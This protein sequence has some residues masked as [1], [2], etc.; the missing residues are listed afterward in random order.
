MLNKLASFG[1]LLLVMLLLAASLLPVNAAV[2]TGCV[3]TPQTTMLQLTA[4]QLPL[5]SVAAKGDVASALLQQ[6]TDGRQELYQL[7]SDQ[8]IAAVLWL[9]VPD[10]FRLEVYQLFQGQPQLL[11][12][13]H[14]DSPFSARATGTA[15]LQVPLQ[16][17]A[18]EHQI[19]LKYYIHANGRL[20]PHLYSPQALQSAQSR[21][22][23]LNGLL[24]GGMLTMLLVI[25]LYGSVAESSSYLAY[26][27]LVLAQVLM[28][29]QFEGYYFQWLWPDAPWWNVQAP[30]WFASLALFSHGVFALTFFQLAQRYPRLYRLHLALFL[31]IALNLLLLPN[32][33]QIHGL[34]LV[35]LGYT[36]LGLTTAV[37]GF[38]D[39]LPGAVLYLAGT[40]ALM[41]FSAIMLPL[42]VVGL[43]PIPAIDFFDYPKFGFV[44]ETAF[45]SAALVSRV[46][47]FRQQ[48]AEQRLRR[49][50]EADELLLAER[51]KTEAQQLA[52]QSSLRLA[53]ASH[54]ISQ[55]LASLRFAIETLRSRGDEAPL[56]DHIDRTLSYAQTLLK[57]LIADCQLQQPSPDEIWAGQLFH[58]VVADY[59][60]TARQKGLQLSYIDSSFQLHGSY[61]VLNRLL[62][63]LV[64]NAVRY[65]QQGR[66][67]V[68]LRRRNGGVEIQVLDTGP[69][70][71]PAQIS[72]LQQPFTQGQQQGSPHANTEARQGFGL[73]LYIVKS[74]CEQ[75][76]LELRVRS[77][78]HRGSCF[79]IWVPEKGV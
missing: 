21:Q 31:L 54:D 75:H 41:L 9:G 29:P 48:Q 56:A 34:A 3:V 27:G 72:Q 14:D 28:L 13:L 35:A 66:V 10:V 16:L 68:G 49:L 38:V 67:L 30:V 40:A 64:G 74:L 61:L 53:S 39:R 18:G 59:Q 63:N 8:P 46:R 51:Q 5:S 52:Q 6:V 7:H 57:D 23:L 17:A 62:H 32:Q 73:G 69:G 19:V 12:Q 58:Q 77:I 25:L 65:T 79:S 76:Q 60:Q 22:H 4:C 20:Q 42:G 26:C 45:F 47:Q 2:P 78:L 50:A 71:L 11:L 1:R 33:L 36:L 70:L 24:L 37:R 43:N 15:R 55:P 44:L